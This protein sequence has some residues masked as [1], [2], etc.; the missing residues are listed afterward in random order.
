MMGQDKICQEVG[1]SNVSVQLL[2]SIGVK[3]NDFERFHVFFNALRY[4]VSKLY[5]K[6]CVMSNVMIVLK[7]SLLTLTTIPS[8]FS[9]ISS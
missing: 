2:N 8:N 1:D 4:I 5:D 7:K 6:I 3:I 9:D